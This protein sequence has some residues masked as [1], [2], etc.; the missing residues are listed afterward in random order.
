M[1]FSRKATTSDRRRT[2]FHP[3]AESVEP[4][5]LL[6]ISAVDVLTYHNDN[7]RT[8]QALHETI[9]NPANV[10]PSTFGK[11]FSDAVDGYVYAQPLTKSN[12]VVPG[13]GV[14]NLVFVATE[15]DSVY[16][17]D[18]DKAGV[19]V[20]H[21][22]FINPAAGVTTVPAVADYQLDLKP[23]IGITSTPVIDPATNTLYVVAETM[24]TS[25]GTTTQALRL[26]AL[27][28]ATG[29]E[30]AGGPVL[31]TASVRGHGAGHVR[32]HV[33]F[34]PEF[35]IQRPA[36][37]LQNGV[38]YSAYSSL[39]DH[40]PFHG[41]IIGSSAATLQTVVKFNVTP[42][43]SAGGIW[44]SGGGLAAD[45]S[46]NIYA[47]SGNGTFSAGHGGKD[48][49][50]SV[51]KLD[52]VLHVN[53]YFTPPNQHRLN[54]KDLDLGSGGALI[55]PDQ[56]GPRPHLIVGGGK[57]GVLYTL[58]RDALGHHRQGRKS[59]GPAIPNAGHSIFSSPAYF[60]GT[61]YDHAVGDVLKAYVIVN[62]SLVG[63]VEQ[64]TTTFGYPG[65]TPSISAAGDSNGIVW[66][67][68]NRGI[69]GTIGPAVL[70]A[71]EANHIGH[72]LFTSTQVADRDAAGA[73]VKF[74]VPAISRG[75]VYV[76]TQNGLV[77]YGLRG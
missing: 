38:V 53:D 16:A 43:G 19:P 15:H 12:V 8:G 67:V 37:L 7:G 18:A 9:L 64:G 63:P 22:S 77:A 1:M 29:A 55:V 48:Y 34:L 52:G 4:R 72:L 73:Y 5:R 66:E 68:R 51:L 60:N 3:A 42:N 11:L 23:E 61:V 39:G 71:R 36:L 62:G 50:N 2:K 24:E 14:R 21:V 40:G 33:A 76:G 26:H 25:G 27:D 6:S 13:Q 41:W 30:R 75:K 45:N 54:V 59:A 74:S 70:E 32:G 69:R 58:N 44:M 20:W 35:E 17:F 57:D 46:G 65:A 10:N 31:I 28:V 49:G 56:L 47:L